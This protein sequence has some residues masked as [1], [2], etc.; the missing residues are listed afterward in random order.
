MFIEGR[1]IVQ[2]ITV[3]FVVRGAGS[4]QEK[5]SR[6]DAPHPI[7]KRD[8]RG[9]DVHSPSF[10]SHRSLAILWTPVQAPNARKSAPDVVEF[11]RARSGEK[12]VPERDSGFAL[13]PGR[14]GDR[15]LGP[16]GLT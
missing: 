10:G 3:R 8:W 2:F 1:R 15:R 4:T 7:R 11:A 12:V 6:I 5:Q 13:Q 9:V 14:E 16:W